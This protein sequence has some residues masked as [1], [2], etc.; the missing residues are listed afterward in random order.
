[1]FNLR[2]YI[3]YPAKAPPRIQWNRSYKIH[4]QNI[5]NTIDY[6]RISKVVNK[7]L[8]AETSKTVHSGIIAKTYN[9]PVKKENRKWSG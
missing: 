7:L 8:R 6:N 3:N 4:N 1:M 5:I 2:K 9:R